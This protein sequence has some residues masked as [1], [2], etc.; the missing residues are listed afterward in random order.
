[1]RRFPTAWEPVAE[2]VPSP[3]GVRAAESSRTEVGTGSEA[4]GG[5]VV[6]RR[7]SRRSRR[8]ST[9]AVS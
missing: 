1:M 7:A 9:W 5:V 2:S 8:S 3:A 4:A 6:A